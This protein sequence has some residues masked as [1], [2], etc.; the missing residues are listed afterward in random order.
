MIGSIHDQVL[1]HNGQ[2]NKAKITTWN[3]ARRSPDIDAG[4]T[5][6]TVSPLIL[7]T[8]FEVGNEQKRH[9][10]S[11]VHGVRP[12]VMVA[13]GTRKASGDLHCLVSHVEVVYRVSVGIGSFLLAVE[14]EL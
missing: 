3:N 4:E 6:A 14:V 12:S 13:E 5:G 11:D 7:S 10:R 9:V 8:E 1:A 2:T